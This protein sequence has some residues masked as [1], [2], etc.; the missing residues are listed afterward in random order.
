MRTICNRGKASHFQQESVFLGRGAND[1]GELSSIIIGLAPG[2]PSPVAAMR[3]LET[4]I[5]FTTNSPNSTHFHDQKLR[6]R[7]C[8]RR[9]ATLT[10]GFES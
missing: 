10:T 2:P 1:D 7:G 3:R 8:E 6:R 9:P 4:N 5:Q